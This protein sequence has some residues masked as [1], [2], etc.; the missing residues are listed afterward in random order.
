MS[1]SDL[2]L[3]LV[4]H[5]VEIDKDPKSRKLFGSF[6]FGSKPGAFGC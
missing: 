4:E 2:R 5:W 3:L 6:H 1:E